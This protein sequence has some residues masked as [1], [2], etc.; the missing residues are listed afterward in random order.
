MG[1]GGGGRAKRRGV[2]R[3]GLRCRSKRKDVGR[4]KEGSGRSSIDDRGGCG[5]GLSVEMEKWGWGW[6]G[7]GWGNEK[8]VRMEVTAEGVDV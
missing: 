3:V 7:K 6:R 2:G 4:E 5:R 1:G 8:G